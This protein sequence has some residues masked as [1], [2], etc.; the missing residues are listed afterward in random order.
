MRASRLLRILLALQNRGRLTTLQLATEFEVARRTI[1]RDVDALTEAG[2]PIVVHRGSMGGI[3]LGFHYRS[4]L[5]GLSA[6]E[7]E[8]LGL[9]LTSPNPALAHLQLTSAVHSVRDKLIESMPE[10]LRRRIRQA[11]QRFQFLAV[12]L[13][14]ADV[15]V[16]ALA[17]AIRDCAITRIQSRSQAPKIIHPI[18]LQFGP[19]GWA[20]I[21]A[22]EP[23]APIPDS[24][25]GDINISARRFLPPG[26]VGARHLTG[27]IAEHSSPSATGNDES[28]RRKHRL[29]AARLGQALTGA[30]CLPQSGHRVLGCSAN[31]TKL[32]RQPNQPPS[33]LLRMASS[34]ILSCVTT[35]SVAL[36][37][38]SKHTVTRSG[39]PFWDSNFQ[40]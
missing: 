8:A 28:G 20:V 39:N 27:S 6:D 15:R 18:A 19:L 16:V 32:S 36:P 1:M 35:T 11:R 37:R 40:V 5:V 26:V 10:L 14:P 30:I 4:R 34:G 23:E 17:A 25:V 33:W 21:D 2:V 29:P 3:E 22:R 7:A 13:Q 12:P 31:L 9:L 38:D 24:D